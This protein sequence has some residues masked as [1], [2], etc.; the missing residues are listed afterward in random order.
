MILP[1]GDL[2]VFGP[3]LPGA[4]SYISTDSLRSIGQLA[5][6]EGELIAQSCPNWKLGGPHPYL[7]MLKEM[8]SMYLHSR[9]VGQFL[10]SAEVCAI[11]DDLIPALEDEG[12]SGWK[13]SPVRLFRDRKCKQRLEGFSE[14]RIS[15]RVCVDIGRSGVK[16]R[17]KCDLCGATHYSHWNQEMGLHFLGDLEDWPDIF[18]TEPLITLAIVVKRQFAEYVVNNSLRPVMLTEFQEFARTAFS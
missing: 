11:R 5:E 3:V 2:F 4:Y 8:Y 17:Y 1:A 7:P 15:G 16:T 18:M 14:M 10:W 9:S 12:F 13:V 6:C